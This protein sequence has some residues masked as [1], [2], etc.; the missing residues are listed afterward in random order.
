MQAAAPA[1]PV[2]VQDFDA[3]EAQELEAMVEAEREELGEED[4]L[5]AR[6]APQE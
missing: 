6:E 5:L 2:V 4:D 3:S 1:A